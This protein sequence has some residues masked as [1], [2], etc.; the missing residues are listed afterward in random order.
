MSCPA[1][2]TL[3]ILVFFKVQL[4]TKLYALPPLALSLIEKTINPYLVLGGVQGVCTITPPVGFSRS[5]NPDVPTSAPQYTMM[6]QFPLYVYGAQPCKP[7]DVSY[8]TY[9]CADFADS[10]A[11]LLQSP[12]GTL[13]AQ[14]RA[15]LEDFLGAPLNY[16]EFLVIGCM[17]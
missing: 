15:V 8:I 7:V 4:S 6:L 5:Y 17:E 16:L 13:Y 3:T 14:L 9:Q 11:V 1:E 12:S 10:L 2:T